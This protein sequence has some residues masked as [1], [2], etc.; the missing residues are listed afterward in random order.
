MSSRSSSRNPEYDRGRASVVYQ[1]QQ[2]LGGWLKSFRWNWY[3]TLTFSHDISSERAR[4]VLES[5]LSELEAIHRDTLSCLIATE[6]KTFSG[7]GKPAGRV[8][9]HLLVG[10]AVSLTER[11]FSDLWEHPRYGGNRTSGAAAD[12]QAYDPDGDAAFYVLKST[13][14]SAWD[15]I[16]RNL[17]LVSPVAPASAANNCRTRRKLRRSAERR[18]CAIAGS[19]LTAKPSPIRKRMG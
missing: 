9:F 3:V 19:V 11:A 4:A 16:F 1:H 18:A 15:P 7:L 2:G 17:E 5:Y 10:C 8:H 6:Q 14:H 12:V 13:D